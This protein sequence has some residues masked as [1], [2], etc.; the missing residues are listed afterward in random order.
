MFIGFLLEIYERILIERGWSGR[1]MEEE[2]G[3]NT[4]TSSP[5]R[6]I[7]LIEDVNE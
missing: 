5:L 1:G 2:K 7:D 4:K 3:M 6:T